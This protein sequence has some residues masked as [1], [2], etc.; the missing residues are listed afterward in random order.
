MQLLHLAGRMRAAGLFTV[1]ALTKPFAFEGPRKMEAASFLI[2]QLAEASHFIAVVEQVA[3]SPLCSWS[4]ATCSIRPAHTALT[5]SN[6]GRATI[7]KQ[8]V[9]ETNLPAA[10][11]QH[12][13][14]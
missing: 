5:S 7:Q 6:L 14:I 8:L 12:C 2:S 10:H 1:V 9:S 13:L 11:N 4:H 3:A